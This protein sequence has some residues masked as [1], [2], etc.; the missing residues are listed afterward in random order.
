MQA[1]R[2][3][4]TRWRPSRG[5]TPV[6]A[7]TPWRPS[8][9]TSRGVTDG[10]VLFRELDQEVLERLLVRR[11]VHRCLLA[12]ERVELRLDR[13]LLALERGDARVVRCRVRRGRDAPGPPTEEH[14]PSE[15]SVSRLRV[16]RRGSRL[17][18]VVVELRVLGQEV[19]LALVR[20]RDFAS[21][22]IERLEHGDASILVRIGDIGRI[23]LDEIGGE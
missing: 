15:R 12:P 17:V 10:L 14:A 21:S 2:S 3:R 1:D 18:A 16:R 11:R 5:T 19:V 20:T 22:V 9:P 7:R 23:C 4:T 8:W 13:V 6:G